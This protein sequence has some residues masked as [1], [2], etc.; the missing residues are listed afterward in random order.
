MSLCSM[1]Q[2]FQSLQ[3]S[4]LP[5]YIAYHYYRS[6]GWVPKSGL[7]FGADFSKSL[8]ISYYYYRS[9]GWRIS[10]SYYTVYHYYRSK[11]WM[12]KSG[13]KFG[14]DFS[15]SGYF[16]HIPVCLTTYC[17][18]TTGVGDGCPSRD[19]NLGRISVSQ[20]ISGIPVSP[21]KRTA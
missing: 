6:K 9:K 1:W 21:V 10:V 12:P 8:H 11:G 7:K 19:S 20:D 16:T 13:L 4:F 18:T 17:T 3:P 5:N 2:A 15:K 14:A